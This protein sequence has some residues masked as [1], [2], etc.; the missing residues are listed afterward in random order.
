MAHGIKIRKLH[1]V[2]FTWHDRLFRPWTKTFVGEAIEEEGK[3]KKKKKTRWMTEWS[4]L[5]PYL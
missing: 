4:T 1:R 3:K 2:N 5:L